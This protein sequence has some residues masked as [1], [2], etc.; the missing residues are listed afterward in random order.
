MTKNA[1]KSPQ[2]RE[3]VITNLSQCMNLGNITNARTKLFV[4]PYL[5]SNHRVHIEYVNDSWFKVSCSIIALL[6][7]DYGYIH[8][9]EILLEAILIINGNHELTVDMKQ[10]SKVGSLTGT[11]LSYISK[12]ISST[13]PRRSIPGF[14]SDSGWS[15]SASAETNAINF[16][17]GATLWE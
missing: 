17:F 9:R 13:G 15:V 2:K 12:K 6:K 4:S 1:D 14:S 11:Y 16:P 7:T 5:S 3:Y 10:L 8:E